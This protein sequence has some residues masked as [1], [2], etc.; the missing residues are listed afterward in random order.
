MA[1]KQ[2]PWTIDPADF[3]T[4]VEQVKA[5]SRTCS[6][7]RDGSRSRCC[8][9]S[10]TA[11]RSSLATSASVRGSTS[12]SPVNSFRATSIRGDAWPGSAA[13]RSVPLPH[14][15]RATVGRQ[16]GTMRC[17]MRSTSARQCWP[18]PTCTGQTARDST[19]RGSPRGRGKSAP[20]VVIDGTQSVGALDF[21][22]DDVRPDAVMCAAYKWLMGPY[23]M[24]L[25]WFGDVLQEG[26]P[27]EETWAGRRDSDDFRGLV[28]YTDAY[29]PGS[30]RFDVGQRSNFTMLPMTIEA[31]RLVKSWGTARI[32]AHC[33]ACCGRQCW[34]RLREAGYAIEAPRGVA[35]HLVGLRPPAGADTSAWRPASSRPMFTS[36]GAARRSR[37]S[38]LVQHAGGHAGAQRRVDGERS[39]VTTGTQEHRSTGDRSTVRRF[40]SRGVAGGRW[41]VLNS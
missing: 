30:V 4:D 10:L 14:Q 1:R 34:T 16:P 33:A 15:R 31:L 25:G 23:G 3:F 21:P 22:F 39:A 38:P 26:E 36:P 29:G 37:L 28:D 27:I 18:S 40:P 41:E 5:R 9:A 11:W 2:R 19:C 12:S 35:H 32:Q 20:W 17:T 13:A 7:R 8:R 6:A 24:A